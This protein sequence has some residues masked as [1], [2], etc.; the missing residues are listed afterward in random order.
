MGETD[1]GDQGPSG[2]TDVSMT[3][4]DGQCCSAQRGDLQPCTAVPD[5]QQQPW[6]AA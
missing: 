4:K 5:A 6:I 3:R 2:R 1:I